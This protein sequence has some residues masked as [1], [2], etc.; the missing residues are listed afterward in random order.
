MGRGKAASKLGIPMASG[1]VL[2]GQKVGQ[3]SLVRIWSE[4]FCCRREQAL[5]TNLMAKFYQPGP[6]GQG[7]RREWKAFRS[8]PGQQALA[9]NDVLRPS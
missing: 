2:S 7:S 4:G 3:Q 6:L 1:H 8:P 9:P 5:D